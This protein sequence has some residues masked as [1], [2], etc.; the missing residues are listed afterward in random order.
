MNSFYCFVYKFINYFILSQVVFSKISE[1]L[2]ILS[3]LVG[4][5]GFEAEQS[6]ADIGY[7]LRWKPC[8]AL[9][10]VLNLS[11]QAP[12]EFIGFNESFKRRFESAEISMKKGLHSI[13]ALTGKRSFAEI[14][15]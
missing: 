9:H 1:R 6:S 15:E 2:T 11:N 10:L 4:L 12:I 14:P 7:W 5:F 13:G 8:T 3:R